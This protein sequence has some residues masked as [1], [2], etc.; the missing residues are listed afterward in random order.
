VF[1]QNVIPSLKENNFGHDEETVRAVCSLGKQIIS[2]KPNA[3]FNSKPGKRRSVSYL[4]SS[5]QGEPEKLSQEV[6]SEQF[7]CGSFVS[8]TQCVETTN[9]SQPQEIEASSPCSD[10]NKTDKQ[11]TVDPVLLEYEEPVVILFCKSINK[12]QANSF[13]DRIS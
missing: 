11:L 10:Q 4:S 9:L 2:Q 13:C 7:K 3:N 12:T 1:T 6:Y 5:Y 8:S